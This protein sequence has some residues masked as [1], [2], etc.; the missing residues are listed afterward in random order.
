MKKGTILG[1]T[2]E[3]LAELGVSSAKKTVKSVAQIV[4][5]FSK[6]ESHESN[7]SNKSHSPE[8]NRGKDH[9]PLDFKKLQNKFQDKD[10]LKAEAL[11]N[12]LFQLVKREDE[13][14]L[15]RKDMD[16]EQKKRQE[17][18]EVE[19]KKRKEQQQKIQSQQGVIPT[20]KAKRGFMSRKKSSEQQHVE[21]KPASGKQ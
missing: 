16:E 2:F 14:I 6:N 7:E 11:K 17:E 20:G 13:K 1:D 9:T 19:E 10:K 5:P 8:V 4:N 3:Q 18:Y 15:E 21:N 12:R